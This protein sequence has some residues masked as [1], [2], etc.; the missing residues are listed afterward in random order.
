MIKIIQENETIYAKIIRASYKTQD[1]EF[2]TSET[3]EMQF[4]VISYPK[5][6]KTG[7]HCHNK[8]FKKSS[9]VDEIIMVQQGSARVDFYN[10]KGAYIKSAEIFQGDILI[11]FKGGHNIIFYEDTKTYTIKTGVYSKDKNKTRIVGVNNSELV[12][13][14]D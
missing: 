2:F 14:N 11:L 4:G 5:N 10:T 8:I 6:H 3:D 9:T 7:A 12:I 13:E 1:N